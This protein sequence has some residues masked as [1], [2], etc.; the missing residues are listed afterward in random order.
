[1]WI[2]LL[3]TA[4]L[5]VCAGAV[6]LKIT[7]SAQPR[8][9]SAD[10]PALSLDGY[11]LAFEERFAQLDISERPGAGSRWYSHTPWGGDFG[12]AR[13]AGPG[14]GG[15]F[16]ATAEGLDVTARKAPDGRWTSGLISS[17]DRD[18]PS[19][20]GFTQAYGYF[21]MKA[22][23]PS[24]G[25]LWPAFWLIGTDKSSSAAEI[26]VME[27]YGGFPEYYHC[28]AHIWR[29]SGKS[30]AKDFL[31]RVPRNM[32]SD[33][34]NLFG[35]LIDARNT[36]FTLNRHVVAEMETP[37]EYRQP[38][39]IL[40]DLA[41]GGGWSTASLSSPQTMKIAAIRA[42]APPPGAQP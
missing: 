4:V 23:L 15:P 19:G 2:G 17:R 16:S 40:A 8:T 11:K 22:K 24:G 28:V 26:D 21:E 5:A 35:V 34:Y 33:Q 25:G 36:R 7:A 12:E 41:L 13:F 30:W 37:P 27:A 10:G 29:K 18:G 39:Y 1:M 31:I 6:S 38:F 20:Y 3:V 32:L 42:F 14:P 9:Y